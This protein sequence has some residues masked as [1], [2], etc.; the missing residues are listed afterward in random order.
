M[1]EI[2]LEQNYS[3]HNLFNKK[4]T[5]IYK[6]PSKKSEQREKKLSPRKRRC[7]FRLLCFNNFLAL[8][9][10]YPKTRKFDREQ[11]KKKLI[12]KTHF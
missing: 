7:K 12:E 11:T 3:F 8:F 1:L 6:L 4:K 5:L 2:T 10:F 9:T